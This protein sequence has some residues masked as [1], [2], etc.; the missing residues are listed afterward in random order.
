MCRAGAQSAC[1]G[2]TEKLRSGVNGKVRDVIQRAVGRILVG[3]DLSGSTPQLVIG[4][5]E[6]PIADATLVTD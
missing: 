6:V 5:T 2:L 4:S 1:R 3:V